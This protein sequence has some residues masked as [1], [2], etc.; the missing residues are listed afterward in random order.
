MGKKSKGRSKGQPSVYNADV[1]LNTNGN[2]DDSET[3]FYDDVGYFSYA[4]MH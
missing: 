4:F 3:E 1:S 2:D